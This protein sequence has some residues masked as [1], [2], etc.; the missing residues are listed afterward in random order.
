MPLYNPTDETL[1]AVLANHGCEVEVDQA[2]GQCYW[3]Q[4][5]GDPSFR[6]AVEFG[7][8]VSKFEEACNTVLAASAAKATSATDLP[9]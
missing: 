1:I 7:S 3:V 2:D 6:T 5:I 8:P 9:V 4:K